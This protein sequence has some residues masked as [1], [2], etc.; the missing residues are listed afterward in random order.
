MW[1]ACVNRSKLHAGPTGEQEALGP[2]RGTRAGGGA[3]LVFRGSVK[4]ACDSGGVCV[5]MC[6][7]LGC[8]LSFTT[9]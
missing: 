5:S 3:V 2:G 4:C 8:T 1:C 7:P 9:G 6:V